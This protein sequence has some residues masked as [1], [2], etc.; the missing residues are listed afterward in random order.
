MTKPGT[1]EFHG[2]AFYLFNDDSLTGSKL[3]G[4]TVIS[5]PFEDTNFGFNVSGPII[6][7]K[8]F[9]TVAYEEV[10]D[11]GT[12]NTGPAGAGFANDS[13]NGIDIDTANQIKD[14]LLAQYDRDVGFLCAGDPR[15]LGLDSGGALLWFRLVAHRV[16]ATRVRCRRGSPPSR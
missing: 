8:L 16:V 2:S 5:D 3:E 10:D 1:N 6:K 13:S 11:I 4:R 12:Q 9:F 15:G 14:I 7:D